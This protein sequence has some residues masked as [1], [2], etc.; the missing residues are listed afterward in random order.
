MG[1]YSSNPA[2]IGRM[3]IKKFSVV[4]VL[5]V[6]I[7]SGC[8]TSRE[9]HEQRRKEQSAQQL[10]TEAQSSMKVGNW[11]TAV[12][13]LERLDSL[14]PFGA[15]SQ[16]AQLDLIYAYYQN[17][18]TE[19]AVS[20]ADRFIRQNPRH[21]HLDYVYFMK[22][23]VHFYSELG[24]LREA[25]AAELSQRDASTAS[26]AFG[27]FAELIKRY[28]DSPYAADARQRMVYLRDRLAAHE[29]HVADYYIKREA[30]LAAANRARNVIEHFPGAANTPEAL[31]IMV[32]SYEKLGMTELANE[33]R[34]V[35][36]HNYPNRVADID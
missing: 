31:I 24:F 12:E 6:L 28:P 21:S 25:F 16:Q 3:L 22:G 15:F 2:K 10:Y 19:S 20:A 18:D 5:A 9:A 36:A 30:W 33:S 17:N 11:R 8:A 27:D 26:K 1:R 32:E 13:K 14:Y 4:V 23:L 34:K 35:L 7:L 29:L